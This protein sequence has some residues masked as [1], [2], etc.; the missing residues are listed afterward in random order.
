MTLTQAFGLGCR[1]S[2]LL[3]L[4]KLTELTVTI[5]SQ[6]LSAMANAACFPDADYLP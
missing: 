5:S 6:T 1:V 4:A 3:G 2:A